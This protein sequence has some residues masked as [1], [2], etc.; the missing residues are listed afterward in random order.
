MARRNK[1]H[2]ATK[3]ACE[4]D[5]CFL[6]T[7]GKTEYW[8]L[9]PFKESIPQ[10]K[11]R[12]KDDVPAFCWTNTFTFLTDTVSTGLHAFSHCD[13]CANTLSLY[14]SLHLLSPLS[15]SLKKKK[16]KSP[17]RQEGK[18]P[19]GGVFFSFPRRRMSSFSTH[20]DN[21]KTLCT[22]LLSHLEK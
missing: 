9:L 17:S 2:Q 10:K 11:R 6:L 15:S 22:E 16:K 1:L 3:A 7:V 18:L 21:Q 19:A 13:G 4:W 8:L 20:A 12:K 5:K 14:L